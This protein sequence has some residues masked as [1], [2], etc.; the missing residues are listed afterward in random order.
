[1]AGAARNWA[2]AVTLTLGLGACLDE[3]GSSFEVGTAQSCMTC[4]NGSQHDDYSGPGLENPHPF[5][6][7]SMLQCT[8]CHGGNGDGQG[9]ADSH[10]PPP[11]EIGDRENLEDDPHAYFNRLTLAGIDKFPNYHIDGTTYTALQYLQFINPGDLRVTEQGQGCGQCHGAHSDYVNAHSLATSVGILSG[12]SYAIGAENAVPANVGLYEDTA[13]DY[14]FRAVAD[15]DFGVQTPTSGD[16]GQLL[17]FPVYAVFGQ[18]APKQIYQNNDYLVAELLDDRNPDNSVVNDSPLQHLFQEQVATTCGDC[19][20][21]SA[22]ANN[23]AGDF[24]SSGCTAC[25]MAYSLGGRSGSLD[26]NV[27][28][29]E[30][31]DPDDIDAP[32]RSHVREH[33]IASRHKTLPSGLVVKGVDDLTCAGCHQGSNR[34]V[35]QYWGIRLDQNADVQND[36]QYPANPFS[37]ETTHNDPR[38]FDPVVGNHTFNGRNANQY[39]RFEDYDGDDRDDTPADVHYE[40]GLGCIDCHGSFDLHGGDVNDPSGLDLVGRMEHGV[41]ASCESCHGTI[42]AEAPTTAGTAFNGQPANLAMDGEGNPIDHVLKEADGNFYLYSRLDGVKHFLPQVIDT[43]ADTGKVNPYTL[44]PVYSVKASY[45]MGR[46]D[47]DPANG[48]GPV[49]TAGNTANFSHTDDMDCAACHSSWTN[50]CMGCHLGGE[51]TTNPNNFSNITGQRSVFAQANADFTYQSPL[52]FTLGV[53]SRNKI[54]QVSANTKV[55]FEYRDRHGDD[56]QV[57]TFT[58]R[59]GGGTNPAS[60]FPSMSHNAMMA[61]SIRGK[62]SATN[63]GPRYCVSC[64]LT[65]EGLAAWSTEYDTFRTALDTGT[66]GALDFDMLRTQI[67]QNP[68][69]Q[70]NSPFFV[71]M[72]VGLGSGMFLFDDVGCGVNT[73]D[74]NPNRI[75]CDQAPATNFDPSRVALNLDRIVEPDGTPNG[76]SNHVLLQPGVGPMLRDGAPDPDMAGPL[77]ATLIQRLS[78]P[79]LGIVLDSWLSADGT[80]QGDASI[81]TGLP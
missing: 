13:S 19:H 21:G 34:T 28:K 30:P 36:L 76:S 7:A 14:A 6:A 11:P 68:G 61:H 52:F 79:S 23:R 54:A 62:V 60:A 25:H 38:L 26:P 18:Q 1:M 9:V 59:N 46:I 65:D 16:V 8:T 57:F 56:S 58:D 35:M 40:A 17:E 74:T 39:L 48:M 69:N 22:G 53:N 81:H 80:A 73:L 64:H 49:Q 41:A 15:A 75:G 63:E 10:V 70:L 67:G 3:G 33:R 43:V 45:A 55:F 24:R 31:I 71:H 5:G 51:Y 44:E 2:L 4:H 47:A 66:F 29:V 27:S 20:L 37:F 32:E 42:G 12:A 78:D 77:G 50:T 72:A